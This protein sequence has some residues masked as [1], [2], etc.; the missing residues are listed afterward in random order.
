MIDSFFWLGMLIPDIA[1]Q[2]G[3]FIVRDRQH[4]LKQ[5]QAAKRVNQCAKFANATSR[6]MAEVLSGKV[7]RR[8]FVI[9]FGPTGAT[10]HRHAFS[11][12]TIAPSDAVNRDRGCR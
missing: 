10:R 6:Y 11:A 5:K 12:L 7:D 3:C 9:L 4:F 8:P 2:V 1:P